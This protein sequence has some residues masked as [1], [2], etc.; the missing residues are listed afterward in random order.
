MV[1]EWPSLNNT[2][3]LR[4][5]GVFKDG[6]TSYILQGVD[7]LF[8]FREMK[9]ES[10]NP[11]AVFLFVCRGVD[12]SKEMGERIKALIIEKCVS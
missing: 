4:Y 10:T 3:F 8:E 7:D 6:E 11:N 9:E 12:D 2:R 5:K 1:W